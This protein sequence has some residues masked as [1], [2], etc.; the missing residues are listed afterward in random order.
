M[1]SLTSR[2]GLYKPDDTGSEN[3]NVTT[4]LN[5]N[6]DALDAKVGAL[7]CTSGARPGAPYNGQ[8]IRETD[9]GKMYVHDGTNWRQ[10]LF[11]TAGFDQNL[12]LPSV[13]QQLKIG[14]STSIASLAVNRTNTSDLVLSGQITG[15]T[16]SRYLMTAS[17]FQSW[18]PGGAGAADV[19]WYRSGVATLRT[20]NNLSVG[21]DLDVDGNAVFGGD[22][23]FS[24]GY[25]NL[26]SARKRS[27]L[28][29]LS[30][31][32][33]TTSETVLISRNIPA[34]DVVSGAVYKI[35]AWGDLSVAAATTPSI[36][37]RGRVGGLSGGGSSLSSIAI[38]SG[39]SAAS[40]ELEF[41]AVCTNATSSGNFNT[42][43][44]A[45]HNFIT[46]ASTFTHAGPIVAGAPTNA[47]ISLDMVVTAQWSAASSSN[48]INC[49]GVVGERVV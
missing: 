12:T 34:G 47:T 30:S 15:D 3:I 21:T 16:I 41:Y 25:I 40:W 44:K 20:D 31:V 13:G 14:G 1:S 11:H 23:T 29:S 8:F 45:Q 17:G 22:S 37:L 7:S 49:T 28:S 19:N 6:L 48:I 38:R 9:T 36:T 42:M 27:Q 24:D 43:L 35:K 32:S 5:N 10:V 33:N 46:S 2:L 4:D 26:G 18:G 39:A